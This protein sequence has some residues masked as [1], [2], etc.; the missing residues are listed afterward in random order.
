MGTGTTLICQSV[1]WLGPKCLVM[2]KARSG[3]S[4][5]P[6]PYSGYT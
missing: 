3:S 4:A 6:E 5:L 2:R 1:F